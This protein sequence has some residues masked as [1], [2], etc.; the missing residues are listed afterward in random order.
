MQPLGR[1]GCAAGNRASC[2][3]CVQTELA[4][5]DMVIVKPALPYL[6]VVHAVKT[7]YPDVGTSV[8]SGTEPLK[9]GQ[10]RRQMQRV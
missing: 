6:D 2:A 3:S 4:L 9:W 10:P 5:P 8:R 1:A 7:A